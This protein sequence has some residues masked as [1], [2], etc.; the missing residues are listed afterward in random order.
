MLVYVVSHMHGTK[1]QIYLRR[2]NNVAPTLSRLKLFQFVSA[3]FDSTSYVVN[4]CCN[5]L[6]SDLHAFANI[7][8]LCYL[9]LFI[10]IFYIFGLLFPYRICEDDDI[11]INDRWKSCLAISHRAAR[12]QELVS[13]ER[14]TN[15]YHGIK[16]LRN[17]TFC[18]YSWIAFHHQHYYRH[19]HPS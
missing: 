15:W 18:C 4:I 16:C 13:F 19:H 6:F 7:L 1:Y 10:I 3:F 5:T 8:K 2:I 17:D 11:K 9:Y 14:G 12:R